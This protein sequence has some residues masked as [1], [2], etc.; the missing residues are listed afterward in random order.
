MP[1]V[2]EEGGE[3]PP[4]VTFTSGAQLLKDLKIV[5]RMGREGVRRI[6]ERDPDW[7]FGEG[8]P[9]AYGKIAN[10]QTMDTTVFL[11]FFRKRERKRGGGPGNQPKEA[12]TPQS[13]DE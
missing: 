9:H 6:S 2:E 10:A 13:N 12:E 5:T 11:D 7:P 8:R 1:E 4:V 3:I